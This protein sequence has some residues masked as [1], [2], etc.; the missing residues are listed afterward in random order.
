MYRVT[1]ADGTVLDNLQ[2]NGNNFI[3]QTKIE[4]SVF[5]GNLSQVEIFDGETTET[6]TDQVLAA[7]R[8]FGDECWFILRDKTD[9]ER[10]EEALQA[11]L[12]G[13]ATDITNLQLAVVQLYEMI[14][15]N[16]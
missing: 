2:L 10:K 8:M 6:L 5:E 1:L 15:K 13:D 12:N 14:S 4:D 16:N 3:S 11:I 9:V 7:N